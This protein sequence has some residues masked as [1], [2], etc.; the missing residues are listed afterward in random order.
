VVEFVGHSSIII[1]ARFS[2]DE[3]L[4]VTASGDGTAKLWDAETGEALRTMAGLVGA[5][6]NAEFSPDGT[7]ILTM[8][9]ETAS[10][11]DLQGRELATLT[12]DSA[13]LFTYV[14]WSPDGRYILACYRDGSAMLW[15]SISWDALKALGTEFDTLE[16]L[17]SRWSP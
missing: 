11:W 9:L 2:P 10:V 1:T 4:V 17:V 13:S 7:R 8:S 3:T 5:V 12:S 6:I 14:S 16:E 15:D